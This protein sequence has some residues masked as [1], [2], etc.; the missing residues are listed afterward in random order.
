MNS[1]WLSEDHSR[2]WLDLNMTKKHITNTTLADKLFVETSTIARHRGEGSAKQFKKPINRNFFKACTKVF[3][4][5]PELAESLLL[6]NLDYLHDLEECPF[7]NTD[8]AAT[9]VQFSEK[10]K[11]LE[12][13]ECNF[14]LRYFDVFYYLD[15]RDWAFLCMWCI[16]NQE[17]KNLITESFRKMNQSVVEN[18]LFLS[19]M[20][21][22]HNM[23]FNM[24]RMKYC[25]K[26]DEKTYQI[27][28]AKK[29]TPELKKYTLIDNEDGREHDNQKA[30]LSKN[31]LLEKILSK[32]MNGKDA[33]TNVKRFEMDDFCEYMKAYVTMEDSDWDWLVS[34]TSLL[35]SD[36]NR[37]QDLIYS[38]TAKEEYLTD[39]AATLLK[40][41]PDLFS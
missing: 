22:F 40:E 5:E 27:Q 41:E 24:R 7:D 30:N 21:T 10:F 39:E 13:Y 28:S 29:F 20:Q 19:R 16:L 35:M 4:K 11:K 6:L 2:E 9:I 32:F 18:E 36:R 1:K 12:I 25:F 31:I 15:R 38:L 3:G 14:L 33:P 34:L 23:K 17:G 37:L 26:E 8:D